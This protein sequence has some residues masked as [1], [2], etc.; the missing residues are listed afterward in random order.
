MHRTDF[1]IHVIMHGD[2]KR[3]GEFQQALTAFL[4]SHTGYIVMPGGAETCHAMMVHGPDRDKLGELY[5][6]IALLAHFS[7]LK[8]TSLVG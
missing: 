1:S 6:Q 5:H 3:R 7:G 4:R 8:M 2:D